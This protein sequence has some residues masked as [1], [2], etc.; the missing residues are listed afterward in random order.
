ML[1]MMH[2]K[3]KVPKN[4]HGDD[5]STTRS[6]M[7]SDKAVLA[8]VELSLEAITSPN[9]QKDLLGV[10]L[11]ELDRLKIWQRESFKH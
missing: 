7:V 3:V 11:L 8:V 6:Q 2:I 10:Q 9:R 1:N 5:V 4:V